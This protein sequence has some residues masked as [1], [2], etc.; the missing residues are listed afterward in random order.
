M[1]ELVRENRTDPAQ[2]VQ[3]VFVVEN[4]EQAGPIA[5]MPGIERY[6]VEG[7]VREARTLDA[8]GLGAVL[9]FG[10]PKTKDARGSKNGLAIIIPDFQGQDPALNLGRIRDGAQPGAWSARARLRALRTWSV[11]LREVA[12]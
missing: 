10:I 1:R 4:P 2:L 12:G 3:P 5:S 9:L 8:L 11:A 7:A 6:T